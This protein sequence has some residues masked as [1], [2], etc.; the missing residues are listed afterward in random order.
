MQE[1][2]V[3]RNDLVHRNGKTK[4]GHPIIVTEDKVNQLFLDSKKFADE[5]ANEVKPFWESYD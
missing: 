1:H 4:K 5:F 3:F 2:I